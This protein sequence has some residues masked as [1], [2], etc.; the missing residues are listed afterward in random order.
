[1]PVN[2]NKLFPP[3]ARLNR[4]LS[5]LDSIKTHMDSDGTG[6]LKKLY[7]MILKE[8]VLEAEKCIE[9]INNVEIIDD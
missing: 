2:E 8:A 9:V 7:T 6:T 1:M 3:K 4:W 5:D